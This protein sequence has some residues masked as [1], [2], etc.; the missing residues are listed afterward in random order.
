MNRLQ[1]E[2][3]YISSPHG[4]GWGH[5]W[6]PGLNIIEEEAFGTADISQIW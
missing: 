5:D 2:R 4:I 1:R 6:L 3:R